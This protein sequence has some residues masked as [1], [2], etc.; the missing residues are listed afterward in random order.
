MKTN[1]SL[2]NGFLTKTGLSVNASKS[3]LIFKM[4]SLA[5]YLAYFIVSGFSIFFAY[6]P[7]GPAWLT[8]LPLIVAMA[9]LQLGYSGAMLAGFGFGLSSFIAAMLLGFI[10]FQYIDVSILSRVLVGAVVCLAYW[11]LGISKRPKLWKFVVLTLVA[12][13]FNSIFVF[14]A[15]Y[16]HT[17]YI[18]PLAGLP[19]FYEMLVANTVNLIAEPIF[20]VSM[21]VLL[22]LPILGLKQKYDS[23]K[24]VS[25]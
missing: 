15:L 10:W 6:I 8:Y 22:Y 13:E 25:W 7:F 1:N 23:R 19:P 14:G 4:V 21:A 16:L 2:P 24:S 5:V 3:A 17:T 20:N 12:T 18:G 11:I 9:T